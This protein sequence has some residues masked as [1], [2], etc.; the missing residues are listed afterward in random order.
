[1]DKTVSEVGK[2]IKV[3]QET[4]R[5]FKGILQAVSPLSE[6]SS[7]L[8]SITTEIAGQASLMAESVNHAIHIAGENS[9]GTQ[10]VS[11]SVEQQLAL[12]EQIAASAAHLSQ[13]AEELSTIVD[14]FKL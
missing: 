10:N 9:G 2:G 11:S 1:M 5:N 3:V 14:K 6:M 13:T 7:T 8:R 4:D 12:M